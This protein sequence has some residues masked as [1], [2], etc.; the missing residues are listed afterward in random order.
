M[1]NSI[2]EKPVFEVVAI[3]ERPQAMSLWGSCKTVATS[4]LGAGFVV[5]ALRPWWDKAGI[6]VALAGVVAL[7]VGMNELTRHQINRDRHMKKMATLKQVLG[8]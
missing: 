5:E 1:S 3:I 8:S 2:Y 7:G 4:A 6:G